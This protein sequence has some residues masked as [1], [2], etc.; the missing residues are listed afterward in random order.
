MK[1]SKKENFYH[2]ILLGLFSHMDDWIVRS[3][4]ESGD[5]YSDILIEIPMEKIGI[6]IEVK[7][8][9]DKNME[10]GCDDALKQIEEKN[11]IETLE[12]DDMRT[13]LKYGVACFRKDCMI[14]I[15]E[16]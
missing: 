4:A 6:I 13:I 14:K 10:H 3:N 1:I 11:H 7:Y 15:A 16:K 12:D 8:G 2:G 5:G 9:E